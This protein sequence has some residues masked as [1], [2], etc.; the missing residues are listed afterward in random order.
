M[1]RGHVHNQRVPEAV[2]LRQEYRHGF[3]PGR[4]IHLQA[5]IERRPGK[6][7]R[8]YLLA[9]TRHDLSSISL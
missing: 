9:G 2:G 5:D 3:T 8:V 7:R 4:A 1:R 6:R